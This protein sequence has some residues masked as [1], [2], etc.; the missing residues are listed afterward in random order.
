VPRSLAIEA[1]AGTVAALPGEALDALVALA[2][3]DGADPDEW[4]AKA[5][6]HAGATRGSL[7]V[8]GDPRYRI[9]EDATGQAGRVFDVAIGHALEEIVAL[10]EGRR[11][12]LPT[13]P[14][15]PGA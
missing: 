13:D 1:D 10:L 11:A 2:E 12:S 14:K 7:A 3:A 6:A 4:L 15:P 5:L 8:R 9:I